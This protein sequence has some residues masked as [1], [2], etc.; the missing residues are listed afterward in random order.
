MRY[1]N[2]MSG[3]KAIDAIIVT[4][5]GEEIIFRGAQKVNGGD[6]DQ[7]LFEFLNEYFQ[8]CSEATLDKLWAL[9]KAGKRILEPGYF[10]EVD[11]PEIQELRKRNQDYKFLTEKLEPIIREM[12]TVITPA[13]IGYA[14]QV[15]GRCEAPKD[16]MAMSQ[17]GDY[18]EETTIDAFKYA[19]LVKQAFAVQLSFPVVNQLLDHVSSITGKDYKDVPAGTMMANITA[20]TDMPGWRILDVYVRASCLRQEA[21]RNSIGVVSDVK[22]IDYIVYKGLFNKL[23][24]TFLPSKINGK[25]L[26]KELNSLV[27]GEIRGGADIKFKTYKDPKPGSD[28][29]SIPESYRIAQAV[30]GTDEIAQAEYFTFGMYNEVRGEDQWGNPTVRLEKKHKDFF[31]YQC[32]GLGIK[33]QALA[34]RLFNTLPRLWD[35]RLTTVHIKLLQLVFSGNINY[36]L[37]PVLNY[38]QLMA[39]IVLA[40]VKLYEMGFENLATLCAIVR[41]PSYHVVYLDDDFKLTTKDREVLTEMC[42]I[43]SGQ[44]TSTTENI[45]VKSVSD[46]LDELATSGWDSNIEAGLLGNEKFVNAMS[47]GQMYQVD[48]IPEMKR[49]LLALIKLNNSTVDEE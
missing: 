43:Y 9:I 25:N 37:I 18:P 8:S 19:E 38:D 39:A 21:R 35:F 22:Y 32:M 20:L 26:S 1:D 23:C 16:L 42:D 13:E 29:Q 2:R 41:N 15:T 46:L 4:H 7:E 44:S 48:L 36:Y 34:E 27:E 5:N 45:L 12:Y 14:A 11:T 40:Q 49:E 3:K 33:N 17:L 24:L 28:D 6:A 47:S 10:E 31:Y 30:N